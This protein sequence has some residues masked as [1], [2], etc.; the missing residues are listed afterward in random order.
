MRLYLDNCCLQRPLDDQTQPRIRV[1]TEAVFAVLAAVQAG[2][3][4]L[5]GSEALE[6]EISRIPNDT[7]HDE[8]ISILTLASERLLL[9]DEVE[10]LASSLEQ[11]GLR[12][13]D[14]I[15]LALASR[16]EADFFCT[17]DDRLFQKA[18]TFSG[19]SCKVTTLLGLVPEVS[20]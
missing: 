11:K 16:A 7:R 15:H 12:S 19:L 6:Y 10:R 20:K 2:E 9:T 17:C 8:V 18:R 1:E 4:T 5:L 14:A 3:Q 13:M